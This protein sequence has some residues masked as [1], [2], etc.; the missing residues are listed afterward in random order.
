MSGGNDLNFAS[1]ISHG[2]GNF[3]NFL[4]S[5]HRPIPVRY[6]WIVFARTM[7]FTSEFAK[8]VLSECVMSCWIRHGGMN[9]SGNTF[10]GR[11]VNPRPDL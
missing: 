6:N 10:L 8:I 9:P 3:S 11:R 1:S 7:R 2:D 5:F 4:G